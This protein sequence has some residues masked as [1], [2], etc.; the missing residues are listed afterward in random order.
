[1]PGSSPEVETPHSDHH[2]GA[3]T[4]SITA[5]RLPLWP[6]KNSSGA[7]VSKAEAHSVVADVASALTTSIP[8]TERKVAGG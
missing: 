8:V 6:A 1:V 4:P 2:N 3:L 7:T 5:W